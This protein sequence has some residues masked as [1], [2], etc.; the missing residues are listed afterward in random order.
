MPCGVVRGGEASPL[1]ALAPWGARVGLAR[2]GAPRSEPPW[3]S[4]SL[5]VPAAWNAPAQRP[6]GRVQLGQRLRHQTRDWADGHFLPSQVWAKGLFRPEPGRVL[7]PHGAV[8]RRCPARR[9]LHA[10]AEPVSLG[11]AAPGRGAPV[12]FRFVCGERQVLREAVLGVG[13][14]DPEKT[15]MNF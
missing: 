15:H 12:R 2:Q 5:P 14:P 11:V 8:P 13:V 1:E 3:L 7:G 4:V 6:C 10:V 9:L